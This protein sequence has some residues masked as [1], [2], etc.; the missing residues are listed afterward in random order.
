[1]LCKQNINVH[2]ARARV[3][4][5]KRPFSDKILSILASTEQDD[6]ANP[7][8]LSSP[9]PSGPV[10]PLRAWNSTVCA[11]QCLPGWSSRP[12]SLGQ[13]ANGRALS[14]SPS[15]ISLTTRRMEVFPEDSW[16]RNRRLVLVSISTDQA[17]HIALNRRD[18]SPALLTFETSNL[19]VQAHSFRS[20]FTVIR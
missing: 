16:T 9:Y 20:K 7:R 5:P 6:P 4:I 14:G 1:M 11:R 12:L 17:L 15:T 3:F 10:D 2:F 8:F 18:D 19:T 13:I